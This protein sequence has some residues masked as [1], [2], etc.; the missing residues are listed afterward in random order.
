MAEAVGLSSAILSL[1]TT[2]YSSC[3]ELYNTFDGVRN[4]PKHIAIISNDLQDFYLVL[5][6]V[7]ALF[8]DEEFSAGILQYAQSGNL[9]KVLEDCISVFK[10]INN[11]ISEYQ[12]HNKDPA[13]GT[14]QRL[15]WT[16]KES[17]IKGLRSN[18]IGCK[19]TL[20]LAISVAN[21]SVHLTPEDPT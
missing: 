9:C 19:A 15:K 11:I 4:A 21:W 14:W 1:V 8:D 17:E 13:I 6:T 12:A 20:N 7:Q 18:L 2:V 5:G 16:F 3:R 10:D